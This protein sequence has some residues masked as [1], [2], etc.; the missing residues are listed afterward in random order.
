LPATQ[1]AAAGQRRPRARGTH[2]TAP[3]TQKAAA[4]QWRPRAPQLLEEALC[5]APATQ[6]AAAGSGGHARRSS[7]RIY[8]ACHAKGSRG[9][10]AATRAAAPRGGPVYC[11]CHAKGSRGQRRPRA[12]QLLEEALC[13]A[14]ATQK[15][16][17]GHG[18]HARRSSARKLCVPCHAKGSRGRQEALC[19]APACH[20][21]SGV[22]K[23][24]E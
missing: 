22:V 2:C 19:T 4:G 17:A 16:A 21:I 14:P 8:C 15:A 7:S 3:A 23:S 10:A 6:K 11:A 18:G 13:I 24:G 1:K 20:A 5:I 9:P 12:P